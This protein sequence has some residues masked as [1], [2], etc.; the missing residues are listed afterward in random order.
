MVELQKELKISTA[1]IYF[2]IQKIQKQCLC[3]REDAANILAA[4]VG[5]PV[6]DILNESE[7]KRVRNLQQIRTT[8]TSIPRI[9]ESKEQEKKVIKK[10]APITENKLYDL[11]HF[12]PKIVKASRSQFRSG[13]YSEAIF[14]AFKCIEIFAK[15]KSGSKRRGTALMQEI[16]N[17]K[18]P[19]IKLNNM[20]QDFEIDEQNGFRLIYAGAMLGIRNPQ[21]HADIQQKDP[22]RT[23]E[24]LSLASLLTKRLDEGVKVI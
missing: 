1:A 20:Q 14:N 16:F 11:L 21:G 7:L 3:S 24:Y 9:R 6:F 8:P 2:R 22:Y 13:H 10:E 19:I 23:L 18:H 15:K 5:I 12:H 17:E 4:E